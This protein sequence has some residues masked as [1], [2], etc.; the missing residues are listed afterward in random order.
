[1]FVGSTGRDLTSNGLLVQGGFQFAE[2]REITELAAG[3]YPGGI[4]VPCIGD[5]SEHDL[6]F[7]RELGVAVFGLVENCKMEGGIVAVRAPRDWYLVLEKQVS[8]EELK[9]AR[10]PIGIVTWRPATDDTVKAETENEVA[11]CVRKDETASDTAAPG[12]ASQTKEEGGAAAPQ[13]AGG[14]DDAAQAKRAADA[15]KT[16]QKLWICGELRIEKDGKEPYVKIG[17][18]KRVALNG[19]CRKIVDAMLALG[20]T[21]EENA[22]STEDIFKEAKIKSTKRLQSPFMKAIK[23]ADIMRKLC[24]EFMSHVGEGV[25]RDPY[26]FFLGQ[27]PKATA[28]ATPGTRAGRAA[29]KKVRTATARR[30][31]APARSQPRRTARKR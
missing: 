12:G 5:L 21:S 17:N 26:K 31:G 15:G 30:R 7:L 1:V 9:G 25:K 27:K 29:S 14:P 18:G 6:R 8:P 2:G 13:R 19:H 24:D 20:A 11:A 23:D 22:K 4:L 16:E 3:Q 10:R 28:A